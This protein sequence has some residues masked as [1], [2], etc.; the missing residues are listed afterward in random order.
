[1]IHFITIMTM[2]GGYDVCC[3]GEMDRAI[4][5]KIGHRQDERFREGASN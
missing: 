3:H 2:M 1:M 4:D 5:P